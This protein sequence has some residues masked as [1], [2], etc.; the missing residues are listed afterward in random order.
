LTVDG[1]RH[2]DLPPVNDSRVSRSL[3]DE[4]YCACRR[5]W[6]LDKQHRTLPLMSLCL[7]KLPVLMNCP[8]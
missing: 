6:A 7:N 2:Y 8:G 3:L 5:L 4:E 1:G